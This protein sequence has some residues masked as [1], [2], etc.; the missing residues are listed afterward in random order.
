MS[1]DVDSSKFERKMARYIE[2]LGMNASEVVSDQSRLLLKAAI[3]LTPPNSNSQGRK[4][5]YSDI[6]R[7]MSPLYP[8]NFRGPH[9]AR[10]REMLE[11]KDLVGFQAFLM[12]QKNKWK[13][14]RIET[15]SPDLHR[16]AQNSRG[17]VTK[18]QKIFVA[19]NRQWEK[20][21]KTQ[22]S[23][24]GREKC[25]W[26]PAYKRLGGTLPSWITRHTEGVRGNFN[27]AQLN[28]KSFPSFTIRNF[29]HGIGGSV[30]L[31]RDAIRIRGEAME[32][33][34]KRRLTELAKKTNAS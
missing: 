32:K 16:K 20:Y 6:A 7:S 29:S 31:I 21:V 26:W 22:Q 12:N 2:E 19:E 17:R 4:A 33:D 13:S 24:V 18:S 28:N 1:A 25:G 34:I 15:F 14:W 9:A 8:E 11:K 10:I 3:K 23:H 30:R 27:D 5:V